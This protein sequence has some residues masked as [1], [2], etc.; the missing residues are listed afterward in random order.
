[1]YLHTYIHI[2][3]YILPGFNLLQAFMSVA[4]MLA[5]GVELASSHGCDSALAIRNC[6]ESRLRSFV[7]EYALV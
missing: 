3:I 2:C 4:M 7:V 1:M 6:M 5:Q